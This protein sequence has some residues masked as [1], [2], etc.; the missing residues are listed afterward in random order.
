MNT[1]ARAMS[2]THPIRHLDTLISLSMNPRE[3]VNMAQS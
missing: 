1:F 2:V 3:G